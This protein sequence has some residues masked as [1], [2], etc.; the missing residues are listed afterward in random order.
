[1]ITALVASFFPYIAIPLGSNT[2]LSVGALLGL[3]AWIIGPRIPRLDGTLALFIT[4]PIVVNALSTLLIQ[5][6]LPPAGVLTWLNLVGAFAAGVLAVLALRGRFATAISLMVTVSALFALVQYAALRAGTIPFLELYDAPGYASVEANSYAILN[7]IQRPFAQFPEPSFMAGSLTLALIT[8]VMVRRYFGGRLRAHESTAVLLGGIVITLSESGS[9]I[10]GLGLVAVSIVMSAERSLKNQ[11]LALLLISVAV[12][13]AI[14][15]VGE[16]GL[17]SNFS[18]GDRLGSIAVAVRH[19]S[20]D[21]GSLLLGLG[22]GGLAAGFES[23][24]VDLSGY[25]FVQIPRDAISA[26]VRIIVEFGLIGGM[27]VVAIMLVQIV[28]GARLV[29]TQLW[30]FV[31]AAWLV[32][33]GLTVSYESADWLWLAPGAAMGI[34]LHY[35]QAS[36]RGEVQS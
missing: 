10:L 16:R 6:P 18:W 14:W 29:R 35:R 3:V 23:G 17:A 33:A 30:W 11:T 25:T 28:R 2:H 34:V 12:V 19:W 36:H 26:I 31:V 7:Y 15:I 8:M 5:A 4:L 22:R 9:A 24:A 20:A 32:V 13:A 27:T 1:M 21:V